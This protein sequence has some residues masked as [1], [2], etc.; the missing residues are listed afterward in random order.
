MPLAAK[1]FNRIKW[2]IL[3]S[4]RMCPFKLHSNDF[5][6]ICPENKPFYV[7]TLKAEKQRLCRQSMR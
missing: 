5:L 7:E 1:V 2:L 3:R 6:I 4:F